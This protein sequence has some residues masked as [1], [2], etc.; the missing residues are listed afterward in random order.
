MS[1]QDRWNLL[2]SLEEELL[3][4]SIVL[5][6]WCA[7]MIRESDTAFANGLYIASIIT[8][9]SAMETYLRSEDSTKE[10]KRL[11]ELI[12]DSGL[13]PELTRELHTLRK[14]RNQWVHVGDPWD[15][16]AL[17]QNPDKY[18]AELEN[19]A[20]IAVKA[21]RQTIYSSPWV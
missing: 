14:Y 17:I 10:K 19:M 21:L 3:K 4:G 13:N 6:E 7:F 5:S 12:D 1:E 8:A 18:K 2:V 20:F 16:Q 9:M 15:D 11:V